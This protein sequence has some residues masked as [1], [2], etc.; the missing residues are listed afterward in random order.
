MSWC[1]GGK[2]VLES[3][4]LKEWAQV[5]SLQQSVEDTAETFWQWQ[6]VP[7]GFIP[8]SHLLPDLKKQI[9]NLSTVA[10]RFSA[11]TSNI[12]LSHMR[13]RCK[14]WLEEFSVHPQPQSAHSVPL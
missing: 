1:F 11:S 4:V 14:S 8:T 7:K 5:E 12:G 13:K 9:I 6:Q 10:S 3:V 2:L